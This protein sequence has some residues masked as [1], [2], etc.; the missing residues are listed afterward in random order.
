MVEGRGRV[1]DMH[2]MLEGNGR[3][4]PNGKGL[5]IYKWSVNNYLSVTF[6]RACLL[7]VFPVI[8]VD[9]YSRTME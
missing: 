6:E 1:L 9:K 3:V 4:E 5:F 7:K 8:Y 2:L